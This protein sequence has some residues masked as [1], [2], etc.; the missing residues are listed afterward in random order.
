MSSAHAG[1]KYGFKEATTDTIKLF[2]DKDVNGLVI[3]TRHDSHATLVLQALRTGKNIF[4]EK[5]LCLTRLELNEIA[6]EYSTLKIANKNF[7]ILMVGFNRRFAPQVKKIKSLLLLV[8]GPKSFVMTVNAGGIP[9]DHWTQ[10]EEI[11][12]GRIIGE[13]CHFIDL[14]RYLSGSPITSW[15]SINMDCATKDTLS[16]Q[17]KF[18]DGSI[19]TILYF[20]NGSKIFP[21][22]R[23]EVFAAGSVLRLDNFRKL[24]GYGWPGFKNMN[25]W[26]QDKGQNACAKAFV[27]AIAQNISS[28]IPIEELFEVSQV[29]I[30]ISEAAN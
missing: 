4:V 10:D 9:M 20:A 16:V 11:G 23:L 8:G 3:S 17:L 7:P 6:R 27:D 22:E 29:T 2:N 1:K 14:L 19:G 25:L 13:A 21:K 15:Q 5:P 26:R 30:E 18:A 24:T 28:P 12:G